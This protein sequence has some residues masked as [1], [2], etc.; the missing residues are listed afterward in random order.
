MSREQMEARKNKGMTP[1]PEYKK[2]GAVAKPKK[3]AV[4]S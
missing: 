2:G 1:P 4:G 3:K